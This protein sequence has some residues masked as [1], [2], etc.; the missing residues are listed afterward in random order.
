MVGETSCPFRCFGN[1]LQVALPLLERQI[2]ILKQE[3]ASPGNH[4]HEIVEVMGDSP[5]QFAQR[6]Q[7]L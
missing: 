5:G 3:V 6:L 7:L 2:G 4:G 1:R